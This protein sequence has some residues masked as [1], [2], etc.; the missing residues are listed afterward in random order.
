[1]SEYLTTDLTK[2]SGQFEVA[3]K[4]I[5]ELLKDLTD[6]NLNQR[7]AG[8]SWSVAEC[9]DHLSKI[10]KDYTGL[11]EAEINRGR[12]NNIVSNGTYSFTWIGKMFFKP[13]EPPVKRKF[14]APKIWK[15][16]QEHSIEKTKTEFLSLQDKFIE[17]LK[18]AK[19]LN[20]N[21]LKVVSPATRLVRFNLIDILNVLAAH[22]RRHLWQAEQV[23][24]KLKTQKNKE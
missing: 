3:K 15:P 8:N 13:I 5:E 21:K 17:L 18:K 1:M 19:G 9:I 10:G 14:K 7:P 23:K 6:D 22:Q 2:L 12:E 11:I 20:L 24:L 4:H 16:V